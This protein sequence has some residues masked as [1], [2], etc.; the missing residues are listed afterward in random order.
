MD[1]KVSSSLQKLLSYEDF[2]PLCKWK[3][4]DTQD[5]LVIHLPDFKKD[6]LRIQISNTGLL[7]ITGENVDQEGKKKSRFQK[8]LKLAKEYDSTKIHAK[9][10]QGC[11]RVTLPKKV[12][13]PPIVESPMPQDDVRKDVVDAINTTPEKLATLNA[14]TGGVGDQVLKSKLFTQV[15][16]NVGF[17]LVAAFSVYTAYKYWTSYVKVDED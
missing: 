3:R 14:T 12:V 9:F 11:L 4:E 2:E 10:S 1:S 17:A 16:V 5:T 8:E 6:Q 13:T 7:K 15:M